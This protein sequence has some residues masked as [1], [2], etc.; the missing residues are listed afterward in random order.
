MF[1]R[2]R[3]GRTDFAMTTTPRWMSRRSTTW[4]TV[5]PRALGG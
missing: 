4:A 1:S 3:S 5:L 2:M